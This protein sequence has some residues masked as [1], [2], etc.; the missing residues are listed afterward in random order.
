[1]PKKMSKGFKVAAASLAALAV[2]LTAIVAIFIYNQNNE[3]KKAESAKDEAGRYA[4]TNRDMSSQ[5]SNGGTSDGQ[6]QADRYAGWQDYVSNTWAVSI[7]YP[8]G[9]TMKETSGSLY[10]SFS[11]PATPPGGVILAECSFAIAAD[12][13]DPGTTLDTFVTDAQEEPMGGGNVVSDTATS[14]DGNVARQ[15]VDTYTDVGHPWK[16]LR[17]WTIK[18]GKGYTFIY[19][20]STNYNSNDYYAAHLAEAEAMIASIVLM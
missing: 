7:K 9:W 11:G 10:V 8:A 14:V 19:W 20:A 4:K 2:V 12:D 6:T 15:V 17:V 3:L 13:V 16:R 18:D 1:M 5:G